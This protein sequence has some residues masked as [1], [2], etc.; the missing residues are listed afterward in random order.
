VGAAV[1]QTGVRLVLT[2]IEVRRHLRKLID[3]ELFDVPVLS[4]HELVPTLQLDVVGRI[5]I[6]AGEPAQLSGGDR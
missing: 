5:E 6:G 2:S 3:V 4:F 1:A